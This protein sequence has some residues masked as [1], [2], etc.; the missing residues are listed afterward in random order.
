MYARQAHEWGRSKSRPLKLWQ[1]Y[2]HGLLVYCNICRVVV[3]SETWNCVRTRPLLANPVTSLNC[4]FSQYYSI[5]QFLPLVF[6]LSYVQ[7]FVSYLISRLHPVV[8]G[9]W[10]VLIHVS[11]LVILELLTLFECRS[12]MANTVQYK[13]L[14]GE[15]FSEMAHCN[16]WWIIFWRMPKSNR[17]FKA[18]KKHE[19]SAFTEQK[20]Q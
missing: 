6:S 8:F 1:W 14:E 20:A 3:K 11:W 10:I 18:S 17:N 2:K 5:L 7:K 19:V 4:W 9:N 13:I 15:K 12:D 16:N